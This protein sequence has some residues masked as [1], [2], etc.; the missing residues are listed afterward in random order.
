MF[1]GSM[2]YHQVH[3]DT[4]S[5]FMRLRQHSVEILHGSEIAHDFLIIGYVVSV[6]IVGRLIYRRKPDHVD[7]QLFKVIQMFGNSV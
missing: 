3:D 2:V 5:S 1:I 7:S 4:D 6:I